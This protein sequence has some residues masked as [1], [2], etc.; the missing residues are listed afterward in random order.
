MRVR[1]RSF[2]LRIEPISHGFDAMLA[3]SRYAGEITRY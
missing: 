3:E 2:L 1:T